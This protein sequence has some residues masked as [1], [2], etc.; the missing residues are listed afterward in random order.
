MSVL[1]NELDN[2]FFALGRELRIDFNL[3]KNDDVPLKNAFVSFYLGGKQLIQKIR[4]KPDEQFDNDL[5][6]L[7]RLCKVF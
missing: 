6:K 2:S 4:E 5:K 7:M 1:E 3:K